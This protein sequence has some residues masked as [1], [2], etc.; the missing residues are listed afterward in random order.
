[1]HNVK[2]KTAM[3][4][5]ANI[6]KELLSAVKAIKTAILQ[7]QARAVQVRSGG[8]TVTGFGGSDPNALYLPLITDGLYEAYYTTQDKKGK[9]VEVVA[10][11]LNV[12]TYPQQQINLCL[13]GV[14][15]A[16]Y[17]YSTAELTNQ[18]NTIFAQAITK[19]N[20][21]T[22][23]IEVEK[24]SGTLSAKES[25]M[26]SAYNKEM[27]T[28]IHAVK[29]LPNYDKQTY[30]LLLVEQSDNASLAGFMPLN[31]NF[32]FVFTKAN[33][34][35]AQLNRTIAHELGHG[36]FR[37]WHTFSSE[38]IYTA[39]QGTTRNLMDYNGTAA[40]LFKYQ[41]DYIH[42]PQQGI[43]R[44]LV[45]E[46][47][48][49]AILNRNVMLTYLEQIHN[50]NAEY[51]NKLTLAI[52]T[53]F[54][55]SYSGEIELDDEISL[56]YLS[57]A[58][59]KKETEN[60]KVETTIKPSEKTCKTEKGNE[61]TEYTTYT[62]NSNKTNEIPPLIFTVKTDEKDAFEK[63]VYTNGIDISD[64]VQWVSQ[65]DESVFG[66]CTGCWKSSCCRR[67]CEYMIGNTNIANCTDSV[68]AK[69]A[70]Y[71]TVK[72]KITLASFS[73]N[74][75]TYTKDEYNTEPLVYDKNNIDDG[76]NYIK[77]E[78]QAHRPVL[79]GVHQTNRGKD[80]P[81]NKNRATCHWMI[82]VGI[83]MENGVKYIRF[84]DPGRSVDNHNDATSVDN[85]LKYYSNNGC[86]SGIYR[87]EF[88]TLTEIIKY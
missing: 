71:L 56:S 39:Q 19:V 73:D 30:Y 77:S 20:V 6:S 59:Y 48:G 3:N 11:Q 17:P 8:Q 2:T 35:S 61:E 86:Y 72:G 40:E 84:F 78:L 15:G 54:N 22:A 66:L 58:T 16:H 68:I 80:P 55:Y 28:L 41:W 14:N 83:G 24:F 76:F 36:A 5:N 26:L 46:E 45:E 4:G 42:N 67:A 63:F 69:K 64:K 21:S 75:K 70:P 85:K 37:L 50:A 34:T 87:G 12:A 31:S 18:L 9:D 23:N 47:E 60:R 32:G 38:N 49:E 82:V 62:F 13:V 74:T 79:I 33:T 88:H 52:E 81:N 10:G 25:G 43:V 27:K 44:W 57:M 1:M 29:K 51:A 7:S 65:L 53:G